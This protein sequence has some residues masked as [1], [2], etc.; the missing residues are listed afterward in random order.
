MLPIPLKG[1]HCAQKL[2]K[3]IQYY[4]ILHDFWGEALLFLTLFWDLLTNS[5]TRTKATE[6]N[7]KE[8]CGRWCVWADCQD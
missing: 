5:V 2:S 8:Q 3:L 6:T 1:T 4:N 7:A